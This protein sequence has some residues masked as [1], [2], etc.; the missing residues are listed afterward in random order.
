MIAEYTRMLRSRALAMGRKSL[1]EAQMK[2]QLRGLKK[3]NSV[4]AAMNYT[5]VVAG[6]YRDRDSEANGG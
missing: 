5:R 6:T 1:N 2:P 4:L 3:R